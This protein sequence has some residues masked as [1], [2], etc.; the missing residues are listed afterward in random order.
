MGATVG[1]PPSRTFLGHPVTPLRSR[2]PLHA[3]VILR[4]VVATLSR[5]EGGHSH[6]LSNNSKISTLVGMPGFDKDAL[7]RITGCGGPVSPPAMGCGTLP[8]P[9]SIRAVAA[10]TRA[11]ALAFSFPAMPARILIAIRVW[12]RASARTSTGA[13]GR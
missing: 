1:R 6:G 4:P 10:E 5:G 8:R 3:G 13:L 9:R 2:F 11:A 12:Q 7:E